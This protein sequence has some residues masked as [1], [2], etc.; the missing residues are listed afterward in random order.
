MVNFLLF[1]KNITP[2][3]KNDIDKGKTPL[4]IYK[5][6]SCIRETFCLSY[7]IRKYNNLY[8]YFQ[9]EH[10]LIQFKGN[11]LKYLGPDERS[12]ALLLKRAINMT[13]QHKNL[14]YTQWIKSTPGIFVRGFKDNSSFYAFLKSIFTGEYYLILDPNKHSRE[15]C[16]F[17]DFNNQILGNLS[18]LLFIMPTFTMSKDNPDVVELFEE[19]K[20]IKYRNLSKIEGV[21]NKILYINFQIDQQIHLKSYDSI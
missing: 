5:L 2:Y 16:D 8:L 12:Q 15:E 6:C 19:L 3:S 21:E 11:K 1:V 14:I 4:E 13:E 9:D 17:I 20:N 18:E 10:L 7:S